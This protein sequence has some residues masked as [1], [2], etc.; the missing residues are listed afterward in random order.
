MK[1]ALLQLNPT[2]GDLK[3]NTELILNGYKKAVKQGADLIITPELSLTGYPPRDLLLRRDFLTSV[4]KRTTQIAREVKNCGLIFGAPLLEEGNLLFNFALLAYQGEIIHKQAKMLLPTYDIFDEKRYFT[5]ATSTAPVKFKGE[6]LGIMICEDGWK[7]PGILEA[8]NYEIDPVSELAKKGATILIN[9]SASPYQYNKTV[10]RRGIGTYHS[11]KHN[12]HFILVNQVGGNDE[13]I[14]DGN[15]FFISNR[16]QET[17]CKSFESDLLVVDKKSPQ[18]SPVKINDEMQLLKKALET[19]IKDYAAKCGFRKAVIGLSG[20]IDSALTAALAAV[21]LGPENLI[22]ITM[23]SEYSSTGSV[24]DSVKLAKNLGI[25]IE[26]ISIKPIFDSFNDGLAPLFKKV[27]PDVTEE[28]LQARIRGILLMAYSNKFN[29]LLLTT[30]NKSEMALGYCTLYGDMNGGL[31]VIGDLLKTKV[32]E[33]SKFINRDGEIIPKDTITKP[34]SAELRPDQKDSDS[35]PPYDQLDRI[36][37]KYLEELQPVNE[38]IQSEKDE[39]LVLDIVR[40]IDRNEYKRNQAPP[41][42]KISAHAFGTG[43]RIPIASRVSE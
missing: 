10:L 7:V 22:G 32:Y 43:R 8:A 2:I 36:L 26:E 38:I 19:G 24:N 37:S 41:V 1:I 39:A 30:G 25:K 9:I 21:A 31:A 40:K 28:N 3:K 20:G 33:L 14:F 23:P 6:Q 29:T 16:G 5:A 35:L 13:L 15:S 17:H 18:V 11:A 42:L 12:L 4:E 27:K 34:P